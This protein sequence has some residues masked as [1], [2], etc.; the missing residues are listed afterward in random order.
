MRG[1]RVVDEQ[2]SAQVID[3]LGGEHRAGPSGP[4]RG[5]DERRTAGDE[6]SASRTIAL[7]LR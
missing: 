3:L 2:E 6:G 1:A 4:A 5:P 7:V